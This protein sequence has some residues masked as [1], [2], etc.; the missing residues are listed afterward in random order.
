MVLH[1]VDPRRSQVLKP[2]EMVNNGAY[3]KPIPFGGMGNPVNEDG[4]SDHFPHHHDA[5]RPRPNFTLEF[6]PAKVQRESATSIRLRQVCEPARTRD[7]HESYIN[8][9]VVAHTTQ[10]GRRRQMR[11]EAYGAASTSCGA[12]LG[13]ERRALS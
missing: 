2:A 8:G 4:F 6:V 1:K 7:T 13:R 10:S 11:A 12:L 5:H 9:T 3:E